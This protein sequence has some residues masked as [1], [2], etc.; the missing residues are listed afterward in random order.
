MDDISGYYDFSEPDYADDGTPDA[1]ADAL[2]VLR[3]YWGYD[4]FRPMQEEIVSSVLA[5]NDTL[6]LLPTGGGK[7]VCFQVPALLLPGLTVVVT[8]LVSLMKDQVDNLKK[9]R[10]PAACLYMG[11]TH[12]ETEYTIERCCAGRVKL[13]YIAPERLGRDSFITQIRRWNPSLFVVDEAHCISQWGYDF[14][15][16]YLKISRLREEFPEVPVLALTASATPEVADDIIEKLEMRHVRRFSLSF[17]RDN[18]SF[19]IRH[20]DSKLPKLLQI[21]R[22][23]QGTAIVYV[24]SRKRSRELA[25]ALTEAGVAAAFYHAGLDSREKAARQDAWQ[26]GLP[27][28]IV[29]T[30]AFGMGIDK[31]D[32][33]TVV[34]YDMPMTLEEYYQE[35]GRAGRDGKPSV[36]VLICNNRDKGLLSRRLTEAFPP[37]DFLRKVYDEVCRFLSVPMGEGF[38]ALFE[39]KPEIMCVRYGMQPAAVLNAIGIIGRS[40]YWEYTEEVDTS[41]RVMIELRRDEL[42]DADL[43]PAQEKVLNYMLRHCPGLFADFVFVDEVRI[44]YETDMTPDQVYNTLVEMRREHVMKYIPRTR[45]PYLYF[46]ANRRPSS[47]LTFPKEVYEN[48]RAKMEERLEAMKQFAFDDSSCRVRRMLGYFGEKATE[49][50]GKCDVCRA[51]SRQAFDPV[52]FEA[53]LRTYLSENG[54]ID[55][56]QIRE[57]MGSDMAEAVNHVRLM[58]ERGQVELEGTIVRNVSES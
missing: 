16:S 55:L 33:R 29:A 51:R 37:K 8:P 30:T 14:R 25:E 6:G 49:D 28:V 45:T 12:S 41:S 32:V 24:R 22:N 52:L 48:R 53:R 39:F 19:L 43:T 34:H 42:Y 11:L 2:S 46:T 5:G 47:E 10:I 23:R 31:A 57:S 21:L 36:A 44:G 27:A 40:G 38:G 13:L 56:L 54:E 1:S 18:I 17:T 9:R 20:T 7:S 3:R 58:A 35:A 26:A 15:P 4:S 50:C